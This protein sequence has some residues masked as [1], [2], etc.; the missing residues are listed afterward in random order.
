MSSTPCFKLCFQ[1]F[2]FSAI[3]SE[4]S[5]SR[6]TTSACETLCNRR[7]EAVKQSNLHSYTL[8][9]DTWPLTSCPL[10]ILP[11]FLG[12]RII[13]PMI[14]I[15]WHLI[16]FFML[17]TSFH[18]QFPFLFT[19]TVTYFS[20]NG[21][22][23]TAH[24]F[25]CIHKLVVWYIT[26]PLWKEWTTVSSCSIVYDI[27]NLILK[28]ILLRQNC[29]KNHWHITSIFVSVFVFKNEI[30]HLIVFLMSWDCTLWSR[31]P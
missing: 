22:V 7:H 19:V 15:T 14:L 12:P 9:P 18:A 3:Q 10:F 1:I 5:L 23:L 13:Q 20:Y 26:M 6:N 4:T 24:I 31:L 27:I 21:N 2:S 16:C 30:Y 17:T 29:Y 25:F 28:K 8:F 11:T